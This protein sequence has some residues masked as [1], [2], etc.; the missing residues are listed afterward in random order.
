MVYSDR[1]SEKP[2]NEQGPDFENPYAQELDPLD[3]PLESTPETGGHEPRPNPVEPAPRYA[4]SPAPAPQPYPYQ[5]PAQSHG[6]QD[7]LHQPQYGDQPSPQPYPVQGYQGHQYPP[8]AA[9][10][11]YGFPVH[12][13]QGKW[14]PVVG[15]ILVVW[16]G[17]G[18]MSQLSAA[19]LG[20]LARSAADPAYLIGTLIG[21]GLVIV[22][23]LLIGLK[24]IRKRR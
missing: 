9:R 15:W 18:I 19:S 23:P 5:P 8:P 20:N 14:R 12:R 21:L 3:D 22:L 13:E 2:E 4:S 7:Y 24:L 1:V 11:A 6:Y 17:L 16:S 10:D